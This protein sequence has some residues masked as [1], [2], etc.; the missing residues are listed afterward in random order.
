MSPEPAVPSVGTPDDARPS[1]RGLRLSAIAFVVVAVL[2]VGVGIVTRTSNAAR[3]RDRA[4]DITVPT[5]SLISPGKSG[6]AGSLELPGRLEAYSRAPIYARVSGYLKNWKADIGAPVKAGQVLAE[7]ET[8]DLDQQLLQA[9][10]DLASA[11][12]N[13]A[14]A[15]TTSK[16]W[17]SLLAGDSV[18]KQEAEEKAN[19]L[20]TRQAMVSSAQAN[21]DRYVAMKTFA[22]IV[23]PFDGTVTSR[24]TD[25]GALINA[26]S[27]SGPELFTVSDVRRLRVYV[28]VPQNYASVVGRGTK[29]RLGVPEH[30]GRFYDATVE[31]S[32]GA[33]NA[34]SGTM[35]IQLAVDNADQELLPGGFA[36]VTLQLPG[37][38]GALSVP[39]GAL[40]FDRHGLRVATVGADNKVTLKTVTIGRDLGR[41]VELASGLSPGDRVVESP[42]DSIADGDV[43][44]VAAAEAKPAPVATSTSAPPQ[45]TADR[46]QK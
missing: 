39:P 23:A 32:S 40:I 10:A 4:D 15:A 8:P 7:V 16:R 12:A 5:V 17:Q 20:A 34:A 36:T 26:G 38:G 19:D 46:A 29:A 13:A 44:R 43:V 1:R 33:V 27:G 45:P 21:V 18:S 14:Q 41:V 25:V 24:S 11:K 30:R 3:L 28:N 2:I 6:A 35:L 42:P 37:G 9:R 31:S 22:R